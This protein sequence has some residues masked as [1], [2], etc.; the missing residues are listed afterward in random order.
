MLENDSDA[1][2][3]VLTAILDVAPANGFL[4]LMSDGSFIYTHDGGADLSDSFS[5][6]A[7]DGVDLSPAI[8]VSIVIL[9]SAPMVPVMDF[10]GLVLLSVFLLFSGL[11][12]SRERRA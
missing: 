8:T 10:V 1:E 7:D 2:G 3:D 4:T 6:R 5:Y 9:T 12:M 11:S